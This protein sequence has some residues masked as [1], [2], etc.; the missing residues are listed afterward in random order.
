ME[1]SFDLVALISTENPGGVETILSEL[2]GKN[3]VLKTEN[4]FIVKTVVHGETAQQLNLGLISK[5]RVVD[6]HASLRSEW[7]YKNQTESFVDYIRSN[8]SA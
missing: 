1:K 7:T 8:Q 5:L 2:L 4:G 6:H 3:G